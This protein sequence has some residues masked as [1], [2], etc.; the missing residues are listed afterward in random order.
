LG[1]RGSNRNCRIP[2][3]PLPNLPPTC[4]Q[5]ELRIG[6]V[7]L[8]SFLTHVYTDFFDSLRGPRQN[9]TQP[10]FVIY[11]Y[12]TES[13][14]RACIIFCATV[15]PSPVPCGSGRCSPR[16]IHTLRYC[17]CSY[18]AYDA[19]ISLQLVSHPSFRHRRAPAR[20]TG[21]RHAD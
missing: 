8:W 5:R 14:I 7:Y 6:S 16:A 21:G 9:I 18:A 3:H 1:P 2:N 13:G 12:K 17:T 19:S 4:F 15:L 20:S 10:Y 11:I